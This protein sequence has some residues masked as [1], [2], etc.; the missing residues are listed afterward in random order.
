M[1]EHERTRIA[2][3]LKEAA[4]NIKEIQNRGFDSSLEISEQLANELLEIERILG[5]DADQPTITRSQS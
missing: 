2:N 4:E 3:E 1:N 5:W